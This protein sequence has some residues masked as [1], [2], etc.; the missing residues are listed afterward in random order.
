[1][2]KVAVAL[3]LL[4]LWVWVTMATQVLLDDLRSI[5]ERL[6]GLLQ[7]VVLASLSAWLL[8]FLWQDVTS[9]KYDQSLKNSNY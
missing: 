7:L 9:S 1:M 4:G 8:V 6:M 2:T 3:F 5:G